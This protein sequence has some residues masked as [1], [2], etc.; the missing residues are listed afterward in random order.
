MNHGRTKIE[1]VKTDYQ[2]YEILE[3]IDETPHAI[4]DRARKT[5]SQETVIIKALKAHSPTS[6]EIARF[7]YEFELIKNTPVDGVVKVLDIIGLD[8]GIALVMEDFFGLPLSSFV[9]RGLDTEKILDLFNRISEIL[10]RLHEKKIIHK[11]IKPQNILYNQAQDILK[12]GDFGIARELT[13]IIDEIYNPKVIEGTLAYMSPEQTGRMNCPVDYRT[14]LYSLGVSMYEMLTG[15][16]P[17]ISDDPM[18]L[19]HAHIAKMPVPPHIIKPGLPRVVS[20]IVMKL[21]A[22]SPDERYQNS[23]GLTGDLSE[24]LRRLRADG[25]ITPF[26]LG[27]HDV[28]LTFN[29]PRVLVGRDEELGALIASLERISSGG[30]EMLL[31]RGEPGV[32]KSALVNEMNRLIVNKKGYFVAG[33]YSQYQKQTPYSAIIQA[34]QALAPQL[35]SENEERLGHWKRELNKALGANGKIITGVIP[36][37]E[38]IIGK[39]PD[40]PE[41]GP[42][43]TENR[44]N[45]ILKNFI[46]VFA[47]P[48]H[49]L[50]LFLDDLQWADQAGLKLI[51]SIL[52]DK[53]LSHFFLIGACRDNETPDYHPLMLAVENLRSKGGWL[54]LMTL[55]ALTPDQVAQFLSGFFNCSP[56]KAGPL[57]K[58]IHAKTLGN[59]FF[60]NQF[61]KRL[62]EERYFRFDPQ[63]GWGWDVETISSTQV[64]DNVVDLMTEKIVRLPE[65]SFSA[66]KVCACIGYTFD[67]K[68]VSAVMNLAYADAFRTFE[69]LIGTGLINAHKKI[70]R[71]QHDRIHETA[72]SLISQPERETL[73]FRIGQQLLQS[74]PTDEIPARSFSIADQLNRAKGLITSDEQRYDIARLN[75]IAGVRAK[76][77]T[78]YEAS[79]SYLKNGMDLLPAASWS[80]MYPLT[81][82]LYKERMEAEYLSR[83]FEE[84]ERL[85]AEIKRNAMSR[86]DRAR[87]Y[88]TMIVLCTTIGKL[89]EALD[90]GIEGLKLFGVRLSKNCGKLPVLVQMIQLKRNL[91]K[92]GIENILDYP[93]RT[94]ADTIAKNDLF[95]GVGLPA[96]YANP[97]LFAYTT[98]KGINSDFLHGL[99][100]TSAFGFI[101]IATML[102]TELGDFDTAYRLGIMALKLNEKMEDKRHAAKVHFL[103]GYMIM[104]WSRP[105]RECLPYLETAYRIGLETGDFLYCGI[106]L[107][108]MFGIRVSTGE[109]LDRII[110]DYKKFYDFQ[111]K[112]KDPFVFNQYRLNLQYILVL[113]G[114]NETLSDSGADGYDIE[115]LIAQARQQGNM[116]A[117]FLFLFRMEQVSYMFDRFEEAYAIGFEIDQLLEHP[118]GSNMLVEHIF[119]RCMALL[120]VYPNK[121]SKEKRRIFRILS[122]HKKRMKKMLKSPSKNYLQKYTL[123]RAEVAAVRGNHGQAV[124]LYREAIRLSRELQHPSVEALSNER[125][126]VFFMAGSYDEIARIY[127]AEAYKCYETWGASGKLKAMERAYPFLKKKDARAGATSESGHSKSTSRAGFN[128]TLLDLNTVMK[129]SQTI[130]SEIMIDRL[131]D[132]IMNMAVMNAGAQKGLLVLIKDGKL[133]VEASRAEGGADTT[134]VHSIALEHCSELSASIV[135]YVLRRGE[136][137]ILGNAAEDGE[138]QNDPYVQHNKCKSVMALPIINKGEIFG[139]LYMENNLIPNAFSSERLELLQVIATQAAISIENARLFEQATT[140]GLTRLYAHRY[141]QLLMAHEVERYNRYKHA[142]SLIMMDIDDFKHVNDTYGHQAGDEVL[143]NVARLI[144]RICRNVDFP[145]RYGGEEFALILPETS[146]EGAVSPAEKIRSAVE[147]LVTTIG[148]LQLRVTLSLGVATFPFHSE[149]KDGLIQAA[150]MALYA[151]KRS[152]KNRVTVAEKS[153]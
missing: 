4:V 24:C 73:H 123:I 26:A 27:A 16:V 13:G 68:L 147:G 69:A 18:A 150:D 47:G 12:I 108:L 79:V 64:T 46:K 3:R 115:T 48:S 85:F 137:V 139:I 5:G 95:G 89:N 60:I 88:H 146:Q 58:I 149:T 102:G 66:I 141:F 78:A 41:L 51:Q 118:K 122:S 65:A 34:F 131:L 82:D 144:K 50:V 81:L 87:A 75:L 124:D 76:E 20:D 136:S 148:N 57:A 45:L 109:N 140:D 145:A 135:H 121:G 19:I 99:S 25:R 106:S 120:A 22:K 110:N 52:T 11:D 23:F 67:I 8:T 104:H 112:V 21:L 77:A 32:G 132:S 63:Q 105:L 127:L 6:F 101:A 15:G 31:V 33:K 9:Y 116:L 30:V 56:E 7:N 142:F 113:K 151:S 90:L 1:I 117:V 36:E 62:H 38:L 61:L 83:N 92:V 80:E 119:V 59:P 35:L 138:F 70:Y 100:Y 72:Y 74:I 97:N 93:V 103:F 84:A 44:F 54:N 128:S 133:T 91:R 152:G 107:N 17:F 42:E 37:M 28:A 14:D 39:Q 71:F 55:H 143:K 86:N 53:A 43:E 2:D 130:S 129:V 125:A 126:G 94:D 40:I 98:F 134:A 153:N 49:P 111:K 114:I 96:Y 29:I 10:G